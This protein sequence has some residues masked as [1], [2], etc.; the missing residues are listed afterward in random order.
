MIIIL[1]SLG[2]EVIQYLTGTGLCE[3]DD[4]ISNTLGAFIGWFAAVGLQENRQKREEHHG[5]T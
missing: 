4:I 2:I 5:N 1:V 3:F